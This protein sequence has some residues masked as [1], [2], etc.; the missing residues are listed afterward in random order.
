MTNGVEG[1]R[2]FLE[3]VEHLPRLASTW[4]SGVSSVET[5]SGDL[6]LRFALFLYWF[7]KRSRPKNREGF[8]VSNFF[9]FGRT[10]AAAEETL[11]KAESWGFDEAAVLRELR[12][13]PVRV[14]PLPDFRYHPD[15]VSTGSFVGSRKEC[16]CCGRARGYI[17]VGPVFSTAKLDESICP[18]CI[19]DGEAGH[20]FNACFSDPESISGSVPPLVVEQ[21]TVRTPGF[22]GWQQEQWLTCC[23]DAAIFLGRCGHKELENYGPDAVKAIRDSVGLEGGRWDRFFRALRKDGSPRA[24]LFRCSRCARFLGYTDAA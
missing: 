16:A 14:E 5:S 23:G 22:I 18:W 12:R 6:R 9:Q 7:A 8:L 11:R 10:E 21:V 1:L 13:A 3:R 2:P 17:Y 15:P 24:Y 20:R 4:M 19:A